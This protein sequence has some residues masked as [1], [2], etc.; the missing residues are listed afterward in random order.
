[1]SQTRTPAFFADENVLGLGKLLRRAGHIDIVY[2]GH[3]ELPEVPLGTKDLDWMPIVAARGLIVLTRERRIRSRPV[4][5]AAYREYGIR[6]VR[7]GSKQDLSPQDQFDM[8]LRHK[9]RIEREA[10]KLGGGPWAL[11]LTDAG[12]RE[13]HLPPN[14]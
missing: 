7:I 13:I 1:M 11:I 12:V 8:F 14:F 4:E 3:D 9:L 5:L 10:I 2:P 6:A